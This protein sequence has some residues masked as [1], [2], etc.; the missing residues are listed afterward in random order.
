[1]QRIASIICYLKVIDLSF[2]S[3]KEFYI[4]KIENEIILMEFTMNRIFAKLRNNKL[5]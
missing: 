2:Y 4:K 3:G 1:M 5:L